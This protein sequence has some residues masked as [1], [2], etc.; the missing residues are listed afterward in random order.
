MSTAINITC[1]STPCS[2]CDSRSEATKSGS[3][4]LSATTR[5]SDGPAG[6]S[7]AHMA[8]ESLETSILAAVTNWFPGP[9]ILSH[10]G[11]DSVPYAIAA[12]AWAPPASTMHL[13]PTLCAT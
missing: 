4:Y 2:A 6:I 8:L 13:A 3:A 1:E 5:T 9:M 11:T 12:T 10:L 7:M